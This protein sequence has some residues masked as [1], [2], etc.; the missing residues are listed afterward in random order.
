[1][2]YLQEEASSD[3]KGGGGVNNES[4]EDEV[5]LEGEEAEDAEDDQEN[6]SD[7][8]DDEEEVT[9]K[10]GA[11]LYK[12]LKD[13]K[14]SNSV[15]RELAARAGIQLGTQE[16]KKE[17]KED[18][19]AIADILAESLGSEYGFLAP[20]LAP[21]IEKI[22]GAHKA[23]V[24]KSLATTEAKQIEADVEKAFDKL[25]SETQGKSRKVEA[26]MISL[27][28]EL[29]PT[30]GQSTL[31]YM[32]NLYKIAST[33][34]AT[35]DAKKN[36]ANKIGRNATNVAERLQSSGQ[37]VGRDKSNNQSTPGTVKS[38]KTIV[39]EALHSTQLASAKNK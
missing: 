26:R 9:K 14:T 3:D 36:M 22:L 25:A 38:L 1:M 23:E 4:S 28:D 18:A 10:E 27:A 37:T 34:S 20:K 15:I 32:R 29:L 17:V 6:E 33:D 13:P 24:N 31:S 7:E 39:N 5:V 2:G 21:A 35:K 16:T 19:K 8:D 12:L 11:A 30:P